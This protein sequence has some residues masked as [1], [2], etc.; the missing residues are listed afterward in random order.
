MLGKQKCRILKD[1]RKKIADENGI[2]FEVREC[3]HQ[4]ECS[5]TCPRCESELR[6]L[7]QQLAR[8]SRL[9]RS[10]KVA[11]VCAGMALT[12]SGCQA[13]KDII[14]PVH[15]TPTP[16]IEELSGEVSWPE[17]DPEPTEALPAAGNGSDVEEIELM[18]DVPYLPEMENNG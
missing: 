11:A 13:V 7:E 18:G 17:Q 2:P 6:Y 3:T 10:I 15:P 4:G 14:H 9:G 5:G 1:I 12:V 16:Y 8:R